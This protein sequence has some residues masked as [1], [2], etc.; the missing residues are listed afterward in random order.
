MHYCKLTGTG[1]PKSHLISYLLPTVHLMLSCSKQRIRSSFPTLVMVVFSRRY[2]AEPI[3]FR[4][5][6]TILTN[7][8]LSYFTTQ[9]PYFLNSNS[10]TC[11]STV[12]E[13]GIVNFLELGQTILYAIMMPISQ[14]LRN[15]MPGEKRIMRLL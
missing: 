14:P 3:I 2:S 13:F 10:L 7:L 1:Y 11:M 9:Y 5:S 8:I 6:N 15:G 4:F 12:A